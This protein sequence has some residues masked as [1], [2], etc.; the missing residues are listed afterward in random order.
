MKQIQTVICPPIATNSYCISDKQSGHC[1][2]V[3]PFDVGL[4]FACL[5]ASKLVPDWIF[6]THEHYDHL[7]AVN[8]IRTQ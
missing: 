2:L 8:E 7:G 5:R 3:D 6:L 4:V 1:C